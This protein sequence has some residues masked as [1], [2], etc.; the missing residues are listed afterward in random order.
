MITEPFE[1]V[2]LPSAQGNRALLQQ[3]VA[4]IGR[5]SAE[6]Y[7][8]ARPG[9]SSVGAQFRHIL[10]HYAALFGGLPSRRVNYDARQRDRALEVDQVAA[11]AAARQ[12]IGALDTLKAASGNLQLT[13]QSDSGGGPDHPDWRESSLG[14]ELQFLASHTVHHYALIKLLLEGHGVRLDDD[15]G[16]A[17]STRAHL[18]GTG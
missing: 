14:R 3:G 15:F 1:P 17:P 18:A 4:A 12:W 13:V 16:M 10:D 9:A 2:S 6:Q 11:A 8:V 7:G 5:L